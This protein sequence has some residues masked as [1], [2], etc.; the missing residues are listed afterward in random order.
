MGLLACGLALFVVI[1]FVRGG[2][3]PTSVD[4]ASVVQPTT[5]LSRGHLAEAAPFVI[6]DAS[7]TLRDLADTF[8]IG[9]GSTQ[10]GT[11]VGLLH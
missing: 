9:Q 11:V 4:T 8:V 7:Q 10:T 1:L 6:G 2:P 5:D 3:P